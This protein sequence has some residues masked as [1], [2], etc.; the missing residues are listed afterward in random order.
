[1]L[2]L[3]GDFYLQ[4]D[5]VARCKGAQI[6]TECDRCKQAKKCSADTKFKLGYIIIHS[7]IY[8]IPFVTLFFMTNIA[9]AVIAIGVLLIS[10]AVVDIISCCANKKF[11]FAYKI[12]IF[13][14]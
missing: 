8:A 9:R 2:H 11:K 14:C 13:T 12:A 6:S 3:I 4:T 10:H 1:M 7:L 5:K